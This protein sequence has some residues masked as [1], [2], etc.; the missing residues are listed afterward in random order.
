MLPKQTDYIIV[1]Q[2][3]AGTVLAYTLISQKKKVLIIDDSNPD[4]S[5]KVAA[6]IFNPVT[7]K[8][9]ARTWQAGLIFPYLYQF[10][11]QMEQTLGISILH[12]RDIYRP[13]TSIEEQ[14][15]WTAKTSSP[16]LS[17][18]TST[19][20]DTSAYTSGIHNPFGG[21]EI[22][23]AGFVNVGLMLEAAKKYFLQGNMY[24]EQPFT[25]EDIVLENDKVSWQGIE[26]KKILFCEGT[27]VSQN[28]YFN[29]LPFNEVKGE[30]LTLKMPGLQTNNIINQGVFV[31]PLGNDMYKVGATYKWDNLDW[32]TTLQAR[33]ELEDKLAR[34][35]K[36]PYRITGQQ[37]GIRPASEDRRPFLGLHP[38]H[39]A[40]GIFN[41]LGTKGVSLAPFYAR[42]FYEHLEE[43][44]ELDKET[45]INRFFSLYY[46]STN[47]NNHLL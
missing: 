12:S 44:K 21:L 13:F 1:G 14:N 11:Q 22:K 23:G 38:E 39:P 47:L 46:K 33:E 43:D 37:A 35:I 17:A 2:G 27:F 7:G 9:L 36:L 8:R 41:G 34:L 24:T 4:T 3:I 45:H 18:Y 29:W 30:L 5:S 32:E 16:E 20:F 31:L 40:L 6:G 19:Q 42:H 10:Y 26:A 25:Y 15:A 28:P